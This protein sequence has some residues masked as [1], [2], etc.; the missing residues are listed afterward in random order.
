[1]VVFTRQSKLLGKGVQIVL[2]L[3]HQQAVTRI[4]KWLVKYFLY[5]A[6]K[7]KN[8]LL[9]SILMMKNLRKQ[10]MFFLLVLLKITH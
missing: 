1:M 7:R 9:L 10:V 3:R 4:E 8:K 5:L 2:T 6:I